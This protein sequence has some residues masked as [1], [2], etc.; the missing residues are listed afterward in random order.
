M[1]N[2]DDASRNGDNSSR[3]SGSTNEQGENGFEFRL[4][5]TSTKERALGD[6]D[7]VA[8][9]VNLKSPTPVTTEPGFVQP[10]RSDTY[11]F[12]NKVSAEQKEDYERA[13]VSGEDVRKGLE[14]RQVR[15]GQCCLCGQV[16]N[17]LSSRD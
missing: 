3:V 7:N 17:L 15:C 2:P 14:A 13:A 5:S 4:F 16:T 11:Y 10:R 1:A 8:Q 6:L 12:A 9:R